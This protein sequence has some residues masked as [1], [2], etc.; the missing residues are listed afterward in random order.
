MSGTMH[1]IHKQANNESLCSNLIEVLPDRIF[2][3]KQQWNKHHLTAF[4]DPYKGAFHAKLF[5]SRAKR[6]QW[7]GVQHSK[8]KAQCSLHGVELNSCLCTQEDSIPYCPEDV[9][10]KKG[11]GV[12]HWLSDCHSSNCNCTWNNIALHC[13]W[14]DN[15]CN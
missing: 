11:C 1:C 5:E 14:I 4:E 12:D 7:D 13:I 9:F 6:M 3:P 15:F 2:I 10:D 8:A